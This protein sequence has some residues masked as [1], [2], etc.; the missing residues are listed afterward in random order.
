MGPKSILLAVGLVILTIVFV[1]SF[2]VSRITP[3]VNKKKAE[4]KKP[5]VE[6]FIKTED[7]VNDPLVYDGLRVETQSLITDWITERSFT[8]RAVIP[9]AFGGRG[10]E[11]LVVSKNPFPLPE[12]VTG[13]GIG[14]GET[15]NVL[16]KGRLV[17]LDRE[18]LQN[19]LGIDLDGEQIKLDD[20]NIDTWKLGSVLL[21]DTVEKL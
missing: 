18:Q 16:V 1:I 14:L 19:A 7:L 17:I 9:T 4:S 6:K 3:N 11:L 2:V 8:L 15:V 10:S 20:N 13:K 12:K 21:V 5:V